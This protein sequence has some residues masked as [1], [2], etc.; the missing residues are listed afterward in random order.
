MKR[1]YSLKIENVDRILTPFFNEKRTIIV[2]RARTAGHFEYN[3]STSF[4]FNNLEL[5]VCVRLDS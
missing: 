3:Y 5:N 4:T 2:F 1:Y